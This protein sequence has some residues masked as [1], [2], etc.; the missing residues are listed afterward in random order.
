MVILSFPH[1][2]VFCIPFNI[3]IAMFPI[4]GVGRAC[5]SIILVH[6]GWVIQPMIQAKPTVCFLVWNINFH[7][8]A[9]PHLPVNTECSFF[10]RQN[11][12]KSE[13]ISEAI[14]I[15]FQLVG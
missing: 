4:L 2:T 3:L 7:K 9:S 8:N 15:A 12:Y 11:A 5:K 6:Y 13:N 10:T 1:T 14:P